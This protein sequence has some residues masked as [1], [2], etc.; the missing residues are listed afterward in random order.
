MHFEM[1]GASV[2]VGLLSGW[3]A[4]IAMKGGGT[5]GSGTS[6]SVSAGASLGAGSSKPWGRRRRGGA[7]PVLPRSSGQPS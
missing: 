6:S 3:L 1:F 7:G 5:G 2:L 4:G